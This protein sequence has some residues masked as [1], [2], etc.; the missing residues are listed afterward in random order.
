MAGVISAEASFTIPRLR[1][2]RPGIVLSRSD[3]VDPL[4]RWVAWGAMLIASVVPMIFTHSTGRGPPYSVPVAQAL[5][6]VV[7]AV[8]A[9]RSSRLSPLTRFLFTLAILRLGWSVIA[10]MLGESA[11]IQSFAAGM[12][13]GPKI[14]I[15]RLLNVVGAFLMLTTFIGRDFNRDDLFLRVGQLDAPAQ[16]EP[17]LWFR[18]AI[19]WT[20]FGPQLLVIFGLGLTTFLFISLR[21]DFG[22]PSHPWQL[23]PWALVTAALNAANEEFQFRCVPLA[24]LRNVLPV[25]E[26]L[27]LTAI[28]FGLAHYFG[29]PSGTI[30]IGMATIA[31]WIWAKSMVETRGAGW[32]FG[33]HMFQDVVIFYFLAMSMKT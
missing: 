20:R 23:L 12:A 10:P 30:G 14:F 22:H 29:Q 16:P 15:A 28:F 27:W 5:V 24:H 25:R 2:R 6:L 9:S 4:Q 26:T 33:T 8:I 3:G 32:A 11:P 7:A 18:K 13:L 21:P 1:I 19:P 17:I 31:G